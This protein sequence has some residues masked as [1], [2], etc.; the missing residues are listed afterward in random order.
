M[1]G[2]L[3]VDIVSLIVRLWD[4]GGFKVNAEVT[5]EVGCQAYMG[6]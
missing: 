2:H 6:P 5:I 4:C 1:D 3:P